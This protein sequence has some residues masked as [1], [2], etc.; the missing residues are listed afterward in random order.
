[1][2]RKRQI[3]ISLQLTRNRQ[4]TRIV[5]SQALGQTW[6]KWRIGLVQFKPKFQVPA[7]IEKEKH[8]VTFVERL[9]ERMDVEMLFSEEEHYQLLNFIECA[10]TL[11]KWIKILAISHTLE[12]ISIDSTSGWFLTVVFFSALETDGF[13]R[14][15]HQ[16][17]LLSRT[18][19]SSRQTVNRSRAANRIYQTSGRGKAFVWGKLLFTAR[20]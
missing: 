2:V 8:S 14:S 12:V 7:H 11:S 16:N 1:M 17:R 19:P 9:P 13:V 15:G 18:H 3:S 6:T 5:T 20:P 10:T 4:G